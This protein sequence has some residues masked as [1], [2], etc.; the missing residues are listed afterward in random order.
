MMGETMA[1]SELDELT[2]AASAEHAGYGDGAL[3]VCD[4][5]EAEPDHIGVWP[6]QPRRADADRAD[7][8]GGAA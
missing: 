3:I 4:R 5:L 6:D 2:S 8:A 1:G 7:S